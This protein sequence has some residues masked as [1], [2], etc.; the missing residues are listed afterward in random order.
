MN[1]E[2]SAGIWAPDGGQSG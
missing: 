1:D 2:V